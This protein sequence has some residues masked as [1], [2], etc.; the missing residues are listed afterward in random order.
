MDGFETRLQRLELK[1]LIDEPTVDRIRREIELYCE[2]DEHNPPRSGRCRRPDPPG[3]EICSLYLDSPGLAF[4]RA[5]MRGDPERLKLR[6]RTY[7]RSSP[8]ILELKRRVADVIDKTRVVVDR[9]QAEEAVAGLAAPLEDGPQ[10]RHSL[11]EFARIAAEAGAGP[12]LYV[13]YQREA[14]ASFVDDYARLC[15]DRRIAAQRTESWDLEPDPYEWCEFDHFWRPELADRSVVF[16]LKC[17]SVV[18]PWLS[19][20]VRRHSLNRT[21]FSKYSTG[22]HLTRRI[23]GDRKRSTRDARVMS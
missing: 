6:V 10:A 18:P 9:K 14:Y 3:Y 21:S 19:E 12:T 13:R 4:H 1:Y 8:A 17:Q 11:N 16:E 20:L 15:F 2:P 22:I 7:S 23:A 5:K